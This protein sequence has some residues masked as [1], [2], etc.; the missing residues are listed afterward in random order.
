MTQ[1]YALVPEATRLGVEAYINRTGKTWRDGPPTDPASA[2]VLADDL[3]EIRKVRSKLEEEMKALLKPHRGAVEAI[4]AGYKP[5]FERIV[6]LADMLKVRWLRWEERLADQ[7]K[8]AEEKAA[9]AQEIAD[10]T[11]Q[12]IEVPPP[13]PAPAVKP[14]SGRLS[15]KLVWTWELVDLTWVPKQYLAVDAGA[16]TRAVR[17]GERNIP[18]IR[19]FEKP[20]VSAGK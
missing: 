20:S 2:Q 19:I 14:T 17:A 12:P 3:V 15:T 13:A 6:E 9:A 1:H 10:A 5:L 7:R 16:V 8:R 18:G 11:G 4:R